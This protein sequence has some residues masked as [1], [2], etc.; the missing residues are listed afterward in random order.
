MKYWVERGDGE[1]LGELACAHADLPQ[2]PAMK[3]IIFFY[4]VLLNG[5]QQTFFTVF[6]LRAVIF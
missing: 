5:K 6:M 4:T 2:T 1:T 3:R